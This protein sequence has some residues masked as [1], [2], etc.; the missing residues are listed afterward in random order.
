MN[1]IAGSNGSQETNVLAFSEEVSNSHEV[2]D[3]EP[4]N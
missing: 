2:S 4:R 3:L 1:S